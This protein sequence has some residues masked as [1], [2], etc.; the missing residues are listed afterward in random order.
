MSG[1][2][3]QFAWDAPRP[4]VH[5]YAQWTSAPRARALPGGPKRKQAMHALPNAGTIVRAGAKY[6]SGLDLDHG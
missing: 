6:H 2:F 3:I 4:P 5:I 1:R